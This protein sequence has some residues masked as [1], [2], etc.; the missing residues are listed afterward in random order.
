MSTVLTLTDEAV[1][2]IREA[3]EWY[4]MNAEAI[5]GNFE[6]A[7]QDLFAHLARNIAD[8]HE[9]IPEVKVVT[10]P[11][12]RYNVYYKRNEDRETLLII[13]VLHIRR[14]TDFVLK[15]LSGA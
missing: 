2:D 8:Y 3:H 4:L 10:V 12:F 15:R 1:A 13:A 6:N 7:V 9:V 5:A 14:N 11:T